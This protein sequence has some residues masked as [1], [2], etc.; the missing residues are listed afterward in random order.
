MDMENYGMKMA[1]HTRG[2]GNNFNQMDCEFII[3]K[4]A[5]IIGG[6]G[7][8]INKMDSELKNGREEVHFLEIIK[9]EVKMVW[10]C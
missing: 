2:N 7:N 1:I 8:M 3:Q 6:S 9:R 10:G 4:N 5:H